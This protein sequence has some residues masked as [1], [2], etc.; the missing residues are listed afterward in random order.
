M[1]PFATA[2]TA[3]C[4]VGAATA[5]G[6]FLDFSTFAMRG[7]RKLPPEEGA[8]AMRSINREAPSPVFMTV[9]FGT[10]AAFAVLGA[11]AALDLDRPWAPAQLAAAVLYLA[12]V[13]VLTIAYHVPRNERLERTDPGTPEGRAYW[14]RYLRE[15][16]PMN[17]VRTAAP[18][19][20]AVLLVVAL[21]GSS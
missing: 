7:L 13:V 12:G 11:Y 14:A 4:A 3:V 17:H 18:L 9:L 20:A 19:A 6:T 15:W 10:G 21:G 5:A 16:V 2:L 8:A 1:S